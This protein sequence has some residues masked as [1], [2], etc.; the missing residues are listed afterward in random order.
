MLI[1]IP[2]LDTLCP[3]CGQQQP[4]AVPEADLVLPYWTVCAGEHGCGAGYRIERLTVTAHY[5]ADG[6]GQTTSV[7]TETAA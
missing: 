6:A 1:D 2:I 4:V 3:H 7:H 5:L